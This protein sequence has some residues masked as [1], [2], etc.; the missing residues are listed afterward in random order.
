M[1]KQFNLLVQC[2]LYFIIVCV[3]LKYILKTNLAENEI[4][5]LAFIITLLCII[6]INGNSLLTLPTNTSCES[7]CAVSEHL[8]NVARSAPAI[9]PTPVATTTT[10]APKAQ[11][12]AGQSNDTVSIYTDN[13]GSSDT[14]GS[15]P[16]WINKTG[17]IDRNA[18]A[19][20]T[21]NVQRRSPQIKSTGSRACD[22]TINNEEKYNIVDYNTVP[23]NLNTGSFETGYSFLPPSQWYPT[24]PF[25][26]VCVTEKQC[27][28]CP[29]YTGGTN[30][31]LKDWNESRR[32]SA[33]DEINVS[34]V[35]EKLNS[36]R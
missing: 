18:D 14:L 29:A 7:T 32:I 23:P 35:E 30:L 9:Q 15:N 3:L 27:P 2:I 21:I 17:K 36:G 24:P 19:S 34:Y 6:F 1:I 13:T 4:Y 12:T 31:E 26:P 20:Y 10:A 11:L 25:P 33:P 28:V 5:L 8:V 16:E 22:G